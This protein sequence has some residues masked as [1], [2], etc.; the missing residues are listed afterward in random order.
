MPIL[1]MSSVDIITSTAQQL[2]RGTGDVRAIPP[3]CVWCV[4]DVAIPMAALNH[5][6][7]RGS[8]AHAEH[9]HNCVPAKGATALRGRKGACE[10]GGAHG[11]EER[12]AQ[13][14]ESC[15]T[16]RKPSAGTAPLR[17][18]PKV[19][20]VIRYASP[21]LYP[22]ASADEHAIDTSG[23]GR[24][25]RAG[26]L[27]SHRDCGARCSQSVGTAAKEV[28]PFARSSYGNNTVLTLWSDA[29]ATRIVSPSHRLVLHYHQPTRSNPTK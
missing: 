23:D 25:G 7:Q 10:H 19:E 3:S 22:R 27:R 1:L 14:L 17:A 5:A 29:A 28:A 21:L 11:H 16:M 15:A 12:A 4:S 6:A 18:E 24:F 20:T 13:T 8:C 26:V 2:G 9:H